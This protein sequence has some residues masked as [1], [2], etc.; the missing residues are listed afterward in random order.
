MLAT[1][2]DL[3]NILQK[4][5][6]DYKIISQDFLMKHTLI[7]ALTQFSVKKTSFLCIKNG[8]IFLVKGNT[9]Y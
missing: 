3:F 7:N 6:V 8:K 4:I 1:Y 5:E 2:Q 9:I